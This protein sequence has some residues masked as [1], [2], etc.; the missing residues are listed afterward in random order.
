MVKL[1]DKYRTDVALFRYG[2]LAPLI[3]GTWEGTSDSQFFKEA[4]SKTYTLPNGKEKNYTPH[5]IYRWY[6]A[7][8]KDGFDALKIKNRGDNGKF[9][10][11]DDD[12]ADQIIYMKKEYPRLP[13]TLIKQKLI[14]NGTING[15]TSRK[16]TS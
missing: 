6:L 7:Y 15:T 14:E 3:S 10:R 1:T 13:A 8:S 4:A 2:I 9:R 5:T 16:S 11:I 12:I